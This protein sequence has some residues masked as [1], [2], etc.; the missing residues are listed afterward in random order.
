MAGAGFDA[1]NRRWIWI[2]AA[3]IAALLIL[4]M[5]GYFSGAWENADVSRN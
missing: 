2:A 5:I 3:V 1:S 4:A